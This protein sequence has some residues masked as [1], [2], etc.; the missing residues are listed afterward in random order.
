[1]NNWLSDD[2]WEHIQTLV[3]ILCVDILPIRLNENRELDSI[4]LILRETPLQGDRWCLVGGRVLYRET[5]LEAIH[6]QLTH[7]LGSNISYDSDADRQPDYVA[8]YAPQTVTVAGF[9][10]VDPR[11]HA[12][13]L[14][15]CIEISGQINPQFEAKDFKWFAPTEISLVPFGFHQDAVMGE[16]LERLGIGTVR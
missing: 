7:T 3:P 15:Y 4:G 6:R 13:G 9:D 1:M 12:V 8:Q 11:K 5:I 16:C 10:A 14:T 2:E